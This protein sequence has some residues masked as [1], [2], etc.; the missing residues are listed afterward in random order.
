MGVRSP[1]PAKEPA[2]INANYAAICEVLG[3]RLDTCSLPSGTSIKAGNKTLTPWR[4]G[5]N[6]RQ[7]IGSGD[8]TVNITI[9]ETVAPAAAAEVF[10]KSRPDFFFFFN[11]FYK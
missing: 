5:G 8:W 11:S 4:R 9:D 10:M 1:A 7:R 6:G 2:R 3:L